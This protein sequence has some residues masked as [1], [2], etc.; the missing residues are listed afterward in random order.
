MEY[1]NKL[2]DYISNLDETR[3]SFH[4]QVNSITAYQELSSDIKVVQELSNGT[5]GTLVGGVALTPGSYRD[6]PLYT[7]EVLK[8]DASKLIGKKIYFDYA[9]NGAKHN[10][11][12]SNEV[13]K[14]T[15]AVYDE[16]AGGIVWKG[17]LTAKKV[18]EKIFSKIINA[19]SVGIGASVSVI[20]GVKTATEVYFNELSLVMS[21]QDRNASVQPL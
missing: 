1:L 9:T 14:V 4:R 2:T 12:E 10:I 3:R 19:V 20:N 16:T 8:Q 18:S 7:E 13:G 15:E 17:I 11:N 6:G 21:G 5:D